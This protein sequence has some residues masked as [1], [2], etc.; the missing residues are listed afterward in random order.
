VADEQPSQFLT[1][2]G[3]AAGI[4]LINSIGSLGGYIGPFIVGSIK[5]STGSF[6]V[7]LYCLASCALLSAVIAYFGNSAMAA[8]GAWSDA[9]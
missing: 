2:V 1:G 9:Q 8:P 5:E 6:E 4:A 7:G 3:A